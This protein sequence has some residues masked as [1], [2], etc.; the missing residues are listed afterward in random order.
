MKFVLIGL[1]VIVIV[2][3]SVFAYYGAFKSIKPEIKRCGGETLVFREVTGDY[4]QSG[5][6]SKEVYETLKNDFAIETTKGFGIYYDNPKETPK[7]KMRSDVG[8]IL[9]ETVSDEK[10]S[11]LKKE[12][13]IA[14]FPEDEYITAV[15]P[16]KNQMSVLFGVF[17]VY[18][19][20]EKF[21]VENGYPTDSDVMEIWDIPNKQT[22]YRKKLK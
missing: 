11:E 21:S 20:F 9:D 13:K 16:F 18:P 5:P 7:E 4:S 8:C 22:I 2:V 10:I 19:A 17:K 12:F 6:V 1:A 14:V 3:I 15:F